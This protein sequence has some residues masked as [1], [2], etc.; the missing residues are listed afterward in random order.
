MTSGTIIPVSEPAIRFGAAIGEVMPERRPVHTRIPPVFGVVALIAILYLGREFLLPIALAVLISFLLMPLIRRLEKI[1]LGRISSV[2]VTVLLAFTLI[3]ITLYLMVGQV[4]DL[5]NQLP[6]YTENLQAKAASLKVREDGPFGRVT[7]TIRD[8]TKEITGDDVAKTPVA[9]TAAPPVPVEVVDETQTT[10]GIAKG[11][12]SSTLT[13]LGS[14]AIVVVFVIFMLIER[15]DLRDRFIHLIGHG[16]LHLTTQAIDD[17]GKRVSRY[18]L[19]QFIVNVS[20]GIPIGVGLYFIGIPNAFLWGLLA[21][22]LRFVPYIGPWIAATFPI[23]LSFAISKSWWPTVL[24]IGLFAVI[25]VISNNVVEPWLYGSSTGLSPMA[26]IVAAVFW[27]WL[28][29]VGGLLL[30]TPLTVCIAVLGKHIPAFSFLDV[31]LGENPPI[32]PADRFYQR[33]LAGDEEELCEI[34][35]TYITAQ[36]VAALFDD[37]IVPTLRQI[38]ADVRAGALTE[39]NRAEHHQLTRALITELE[40]PTRETTLEPTMPNRVMVLPAQNDADELAGLMLCRLLVA[41][42][43]NAETV[44]AK[45]LTSEMIERAATE[46]PPEICIS[47]VPPN[48]VIAAANLAKRLKLKIPEARVEIGVWDSHRDERRLERLQRAAPDAVFNSIAA[49]AEEIVVHIT[50]RPFSHK[51][52][53]TD[54]KETKTKE[55]KAVARK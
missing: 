30:A 46:H 42:G 1:G 16:R 23:L 24:A 53:V 45:S 50:L 28:W 47:T 4:L 18:L 41:H 48:S 38:E 44:S 43:V 31:L 34:A 10:F 33:L 55:A 27:T 13:M 51:A 15:Q 26:I 32:A 40:I 36:S 3:G 21:T 29:G 39:E 52:E 7:K 12:M 25:E 5:A 11:V 9:G 2:A 22:V 19:A 8:L 54:E 37:V 14:A 49:A 17:A 35:E 6:D 20:Y